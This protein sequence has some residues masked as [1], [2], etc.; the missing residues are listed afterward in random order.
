MKIMRTLT[1]FLVSLALVAP[2]APF[3]EAK[4]SS[5]GSSSKPIILPKISS[6]STSKSFSKPSMPSMPASAPTVWTKPS[7]GTFTSNSVAWGKPQPTKTT[8]AATA[9]PPAASSITRIPVKSTALGDAITKT[10]SA[11]AI[12]ARDAQI[13][14]ARAKPGVSTSLGSTQYTYAKVSQDQSTYISTWSTRNPGYRPIIVNYPPTY[15]STFSDTFMSLMMYNALFGY[16]HQN[17]ADYQAWR[18][19][20]NQAAQDNADLKAQLQKLDTEVADLKTKGVA[21]D[22]NYMP[23]DVPA[24]VAYNPDVVVGSARP[25]LTV[26]TGASGGVYNAFCLGSDTLS[27]SGLQYYAATN[28]DVK[29]ISTK[30]AAEN[31]SGLG[32]TFDAVLA[33]ADV[34]DTYE[35][36]NSA[37]VGQNIIPA[38][39]ELFW[40]IVSK[41]SSISSVEDLDA[42]KHTLYLPPEGSGARVTWTTI[43]NYASKDGWL[44]SWGANHAFADLTKAAQTTPTMLDGA[45][46]VAER[47]EALAEAE[48]V[49]AAAAGAARSSVR[50]WGWSTWPCSDRRTPRRPRTA[51]WDSCRRDRARR[52][53]ARGSSR[54]P[55]GRRRTTPTV[56]HLDSTGFHFGFGNRTPTSHIRKL[57]LVYSCLLVQSS[58]AG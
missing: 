9:A 27:V 24:D 56:Q 49:G 26:G 57:D 12:R 4:S 32:T 16:N 47:G 30:G 34:L 2:A 13:S 36:K 28:F 53:P 42:T 3:A 55:C 5:F 58:E 21:Q 38:Y 51:S 10:R 40:L 20:A 52:T 37:D 15:S 17:D 50:R 44:A 6:P 1:V 45:A 8:F 7:G 54:P 33:Q 41:D 18:A 23:P 39:K 48:R 29:C 31:L 11:D 14:A 46:T 43:A 19:Q 25:V 35:S 22:P